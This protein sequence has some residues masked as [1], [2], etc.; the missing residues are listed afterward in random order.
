MNR[1]WSIVVVVILSA[2]LTVDCYGNDTLYLKK[3]LELVIQNH[4]L[5]QKANINNDITAAQI[6]KGKGALDPKIYSDYDAKQFD[7]TDYFS[8]WQSEVKVPTTLPIDFSVGYERN[9]GT[10]LN[11]ENTVPSN[12]LV[13]GTINVS[14]LRGFL[15]DEQRYNI[16][17]AEIKGLESQIE[18]EILIREIIFQSIHSY[19]DWV[20]KRN[21]FEINQSYLRLVRERLQ[22]VIQLY[23]NGDSPAIDTIESRLNVNT[24]EK[25]QLESRIKLVKSVQNLSLFIWN[26]NGQPLQLNNDILPM[27]LEDVI[28]ILKDLSILLNPDFAS[29]P[30]ISKIDNKIKSIELENKLEKENLKP[31]LDLKYNTILNLGKDEFNTTLNFN[32]YKYGVVF[33][34]PILTRK[35]RGQLRINE[36]LTSQ[37]ELDKVQYL[38]QINNKY[39]ALVAQESIQD[40]AL[41]IANE[42][43]TN[44][45]LLYEAEK[46][47]FDLGE[48]SVF[49]LNSRERKLF[50]AQWEL[51]KSYHSLGR[52]LNELYFLKLGQI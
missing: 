45:Q 19:L 49:L 7:N 8:V 36:A 44:S 3:Y 52:I 12:G 22:N 26:E 42:K 51:I 5:I 39:M 14:L 38:G 33:Q 46:L 23:S 17:S 47:K 34:Y 11:N 31:R 18:K 43:L 9:D 27:K 13:Y 2:P 32:D 25:L 50:E 1:I 20:S 28:S 37:N 30:I 15:F 21:A 16:Q 29:D 10:F 24:V 41:L 40:D 4:P 6:L 35:T 48:S